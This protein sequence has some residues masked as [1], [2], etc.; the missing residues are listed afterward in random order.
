MDLRNIILSCMAALALNCAGPQMTP[1]MRR[2]EESAPACTETAHDYHG[3][4]ITFCEEDD[5][6]A[7]QERLDLIGRIKRHGQEHLG[8]VRSRNYL[9]YVSSRQAAARQLFMLFATPEFV[10]PAH[11]EP[12]RRVTSNGTNRCGEE[13]QCH[14]WDFNVDN[15]HDERRY[16]E[17]IGYDTYWRTTTN[18]GSGA[19][20]TQ[21]LFDEPLAWWINTVFHEEFHFA[22]MQRDS[23]TAW[24]P[25]VEESL[26]FAFGQAAALDFIR[27]HQGEAGMLNERAIVDAE[28]QLERQRRRAAFI[29]E[30]TDRLNNH[31]RRD[32]SD[33]LKRGIREDILEHAAII[34][35]REINNA[36]L[37]GTHPYTNLMDLALFVYLKD[38]D[39]EAFARIMRNAPSERDAAREYLLRHGGRPAAT[40][41]QQSDIDLHLQEF[42][43]VLHE[44]SQYR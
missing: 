2:Q 42:E 36:Y 14:L 23:R 15:L 9:R 19:D 8:L 32:M 10:I 27:T 24:D 30:C 20:I 1:S 3:T 41:P 17:G 31:Y 40:W 16:Y 29:N 4:R 21:N 22:R 39:I 34:S 43:P 5:S 28:E 38:P 25:W 44:P 12:S 26:A 18:F 7:L 35:G 33:H 13:G 11:W 6:P 37:W